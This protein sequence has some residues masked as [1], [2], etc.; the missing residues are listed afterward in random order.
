MSLNQICN[1][2]IL[3]DKEAGMSSFCIDGKIKR[4]LGRKKVGQVG[5]L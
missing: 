1:G 5:K 3:I 2:I 4:M